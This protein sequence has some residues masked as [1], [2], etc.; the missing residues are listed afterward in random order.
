MLFLQGHF[1]DASLSD[2]CRIAREVLNHMAWSYAGF[3]DVKFSPLMLRYSGRSHELSKIAPRRTAPR[4]NTG[5]LQLC[6]ARS[7]LSSTLLVDC[8]AYH[9]DD[10]LSLFDGKPRAIIRPSQPCKRHFLCKE[11]WLARPEVI[12]S[13]MMMA[14]DGRRERVKSRHVYVVRARAEAALPLLSSPVRHKLFGMST[15]NFSPV[16]SNSIITKAVSSCTVARAAEFRRQN[17]CCSPPEPAHPQKLAR[18][19]PK[20]SSSRWLSS[21]LISE[22]SSLL[23]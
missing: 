17:V 8:E 19:W 12:L 15:L 11:K 9:A 10:L 6:M 3:E 2:I 21:A 13:Y 22:I 4:E 7:L 18:H 14:N 20:R 16:G 1:A 5:P 23:I